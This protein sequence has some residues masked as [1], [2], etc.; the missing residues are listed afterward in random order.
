MLSVNGSVENHGGEPLS[1]QVPSVACSALKRKLKER[2]QIELQPH[3]VTEKK[4]MEKPVV[5]VLDDCKKIKN[6]PQSSEAS[7]AHLTVEQLHLV[8][9]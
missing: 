1:C 5:L 6:K 4:P 7:R 9:I 3:A 8:I 2:Y